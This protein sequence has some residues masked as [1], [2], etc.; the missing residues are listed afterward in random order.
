LDNLQ[1]TK[2]AFFNLTPSGVLKLFY[3]QRF[4]FVHD[5]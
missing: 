3:S 1:P 5:S 4:C 2:R